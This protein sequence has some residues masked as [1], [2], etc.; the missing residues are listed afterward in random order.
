MCRQ[1]TGTSAARWRVGQRVYRNERLGTIAELK[2]N[3]VKVKWDSGQTSYYRH[4]AVRF[5]P[6]Q[7]T[8][9][10]RA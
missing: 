4:A 10:D 2:P 1:H 5:L 3:T 8:A 9:K 7:E 6:A